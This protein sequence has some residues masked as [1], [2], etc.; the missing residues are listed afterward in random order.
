[1]KVL[2]I[3]D[4]DFDRSPLGTRSRL[5][6]ELTGRPGQPPAAQGTPVPAE[7]TVLGRTLG[8]LQRCKRL[9][10]ICLAVEASQ[11]AAA[12]PIASRFGVALETH[13]AP[14]PPW[15]ADASTGGLVAVA[16]KWSLDAWRGG[17]AG[18]AAMDE[19]ANVFLL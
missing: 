15:A 5:G 8:R 3:L 6:D 16:R 9:A 1:M 18:F 17:L 4:A 11:K 19:S 2:A 7:N 10:G 12:E 14:R 13:D